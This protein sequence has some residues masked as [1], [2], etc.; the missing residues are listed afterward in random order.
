MVHI[1]HR[2]GIK[3]PVNKVY[4]AVST[5]EGIAGWWTLDTKGTSAVGQT[6]ALLFHSPEGKEIGIMQI[7]LKDLQPDKKVHW[8]CRDGPAEW[9]GT[10]VTFD[11]SQQDGYTIVLFSHHN[12]K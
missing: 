9:I 11:L 3:A 1:K 2:I 7:E 10:E 12:G 4:Q 6:M 5:L 8:Y